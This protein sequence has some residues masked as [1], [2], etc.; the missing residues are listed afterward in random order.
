MIKKHTAPGSGVSYI[1]VGANQAGQRLDNFLLK[2]LK[3]L[4]KSRLYRIIRKGE[5]RI[6]KKRVKPEYRLQAG[7]QVRIPPFGNDP[8]HSSEPRITAAQIERL[9]SRILYENGSLLVID[10]P[11]GLAVHSGSGLS[12]GAIDILRK[13]RPDDELEL[14]HRLDRDTSGCLIFAKHRPALLEIQRFL[15]QNALGKTYRALVLGSWDPQVHEVNLALRRRTM[16]NG[17][18]RVFV[19]TAGQ[20]AT[21]RFK[22]LGTYQRNGVTYSQLDVELLTGRTHQIRVHCQAQGHPIAGDDKYGER[23]FNRNMRK[24]GCR[25]LMLHAHRLEIPANAHTPGLV[26]VAPEPKTFT[27]L[28]TG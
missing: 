4:P 18:R 28:T 10:K 1:E 15:Q 27:E 2:T 7:D 25:R 12:F 24:L 9:N 26:L 19:N 5:V 22:R 3:Q 21:T 16:S 11:S 8:E 6:N 23:D 14:A 13:M 17:E 20:S